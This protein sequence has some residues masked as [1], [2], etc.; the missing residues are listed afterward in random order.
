MGRRYGLVLIVLLVASLAVLA[1]YSATWVRVTLPVF[2]GEATADGPARELALNGRDLAPLG[3]AMGW[4]GLASIAALLATRTWGRR[5]TGAAVVVAGGAAGVIA[6]AFGLTE[7][8]GSGGSFIEAAVGASSAPTVVA[9]NAWWVVATLG[10]LA[11]LTCGVAAVIEGAAWPK[12]GAR[13][14][15]G[16]ADPRRQPGEQHAAATWDAL[17]RGEDPTVQV[18]HAPEDP[19]EGQRPAD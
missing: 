6:L 17:D 7:V 15:R 12:L 19:R 13:Y 10:G 8:I 9:V 3:G 16:T 5:V 11:M 14:S 1:A 18:E 4:V 2:A